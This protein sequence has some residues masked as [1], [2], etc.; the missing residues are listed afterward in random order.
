MS[1]IEDALLEINKPSE[2]FNPDISERLLMLALKEDAV[3]RSQVAELRQDNGLLKIALDQCKGR[4]FSCEQ[5]NAELQRQLDEAAKQEPYLIVESA[6]KL[7]IF[8]TD[9]Q[10][11]RIY[12]SALTTGLQL[13]RLPPNLPALIEQ[14][15]AEE[16][17]ACA[18]VCEE[19]VT[20]PAGHG[21][22]FE[23]YG[24][25]KVARSGIGCA[26]AI[27]TRKP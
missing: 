23:G 14:A 4:L 8:L 6:S 21:G 17:E 1:A 9:A 12:A 13:Y 18:K 3:L 16:R 2:E 5:A 27:R 11:K 22:Q 19:I 26:M 20:F 24:S 15:K 7:G 10:G 25:V